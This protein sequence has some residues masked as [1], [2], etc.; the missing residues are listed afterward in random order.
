M[1]Y[2]NW[3]SKYSVSIKSFDQ[4][5]QRLFAIINQLHDG[6]KSGHGKQVLQPVLAELLAYTQHHFGREEAVMKSC[7]YPKLWPH[8]E[9]HRTFTAKVKNFSEQYEAGAAAVT[10]EVLDFLTQWLATHIKD[11]DRQY[12]EFLQAKGVV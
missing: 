11:T 10:V 2:L 1:A 3:D 4:D 6:M 8:M 12:S 9:Q 5:H 7:A